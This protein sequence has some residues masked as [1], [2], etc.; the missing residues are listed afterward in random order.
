M[1]AIRESNNLIDVTGDS[2]VNMGE[3]LKKDNIKELKK[4]KNEIVDP[5]IGKATKDI[6][7]NE[8]LPKF[9]KNKVDAQGNGRVRYA[10]FDESEELKEEEYV[11]S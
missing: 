11:L 6:K 7:L 3:N 1:M 10:Q 2:M 9:E 4:M 8:L 5:K